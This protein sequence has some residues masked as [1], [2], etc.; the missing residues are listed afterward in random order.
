MAIIGDLVDAA[1]DRLRQEYVVM[2]ALCLS[3]GQVMRLIHAPFDEAIEALTML[4]S[5]GFLV[6]TQSGVYRRTHPPMA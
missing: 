2:P 4:E 5:E 6:R 3:V 1:I